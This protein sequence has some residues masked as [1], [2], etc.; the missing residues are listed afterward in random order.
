MSEA[1]RGGKIY[2]NTNRIKVYPQG[3]HTTEDKATIEIRDTAIGIPEYIQ[4]RIFDAYFTTRESEGGTG[5]GLTITHQ[6]IDAHNGSIDIKSKEGM[7]TS[8]TIT[9]PICYSR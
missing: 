1:S 8:F 4:D 2:V 9:L 5:L 3:A 6:I 7:G